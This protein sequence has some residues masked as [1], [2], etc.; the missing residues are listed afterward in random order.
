MFRLLVRLHHKGHNFLRKSRSMQKLLLVLVY[1]LFFF[2]P[3]Y[4][5]F[6]FTLHPH[7]G[8]LFLG[9][10]I[11]YTAYGAPN[12]KKNA[13]MLNFFF[14]GLTCCLQCSQY[15]TLSPH[16]NISLIATSNAIKLP[17]DA[18]ILLGVILSIKSPALFV[19]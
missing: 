16:I 13:T 4:T 7:I 19:L 12:H 9:L 5:F 6:L 11:W 10:N 17:I 15:F 8:H 3:C 18:M 2:V 14:T 1:L